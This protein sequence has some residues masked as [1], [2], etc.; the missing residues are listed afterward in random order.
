MVIRLFNASNKIKWLILSLLAISLILLGLK[1]WRI[2]IPSRSLYNTYGQVQQVRANPASLEIATLQPL[3][4]QTHLDLVTLQQELRPFSGLLRNLGWLPRVGG[5]I[6]ALPDLLALGV[7][8]TE[9]GDIM[10]TA[11]NPVVQAALG[12]D[13]VSNTTLVPIAIQTLA[14]AESEFERARQSLAQARQMREQIQIENLSPRLVEPISL[15]DRVLPF[16]DLAFE[17]LKVAPDLLGATEPRTYLVIAQNNDE[18][19]PTGGFI[20]AIGTLTLDQGNIVSFTFED[21]Y[22]VDDFSKPYPDAPPQLLR[23]MQSEIWL[24]RD[25]NWSPDFPTTVKHLL[26]LYAIS[27]PAKVDGVIA[28]DQLALQGI[29]AALEPIH[30]PNWE[31]PATGENIVTL[32][33]QSW[34]PEGDFSGWDAEWWR[35]RKNF[36]GDLVAAA[37]ARVETSPQ[38]VNWPKLAQAVLRILED[39]KSVV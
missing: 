3:L 9:V 5:D 22:A 15:L 39:R 17:A 4:H 29:V 16:S 19:R 10:L 20:S 38:N 6:Q 28:V 13:N 31:E 18:L 12:D 26:D 25:A 24:V 37:R 36:I 27:R 14:Q 8:L 35:N 33:R 30:I 7:S 32:I 34:S 2:S 21:T 11:M 23:Y 1:L